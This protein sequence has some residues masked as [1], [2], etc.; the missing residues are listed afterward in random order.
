[1]VISEL[2]TK[3]GSHDPI[4]EMSSFQIEHNGVLF[5]ISTNDK[6][7]GIS[8]QVSNGC[9]ALVVYPYASNCIVIKGANYA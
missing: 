4:A 2:N 7:D 9:R 5:N 6:Q 3:T 8:I 1:M